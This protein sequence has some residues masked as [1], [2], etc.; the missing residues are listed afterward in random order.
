MER[1]IG[2][3]PD[4]DILQCPIQSDRSMFGLWADQIIAGDV[5]VIEQTF[6]RHGARGPRIAWQPSIDDLDLPQL[7]FLLGYWHRLRA[8]QPMP[9]LRQVDAVELKSVLGC[10]SLLD[11]IDGAWDFRYRVF[12]TVVAAHSGFEMTRRQLSSFIAPGYIVNFFL[13]S[14]R[15]AFLRR[16]PLLTE[17]GL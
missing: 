3:M 14:Y 9:N 11:V 13:A 1:S 6:E 2:E 10:V 7:R 17:H 16:A 8:E 12:G 15:A 4:L 5:R